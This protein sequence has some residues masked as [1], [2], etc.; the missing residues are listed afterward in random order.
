[1]GKKNRKPV[2]QAQS[3][4][5]PCLDR[6]TKKDILELCNQLLEKCTRSN[7]AG[8][9]DWDEFMEIFNLVEKIREK[10]KHL[11]S[12]SQKTSR[13]WSS[14]L[15]WLQENNVDTSRVTTDEFPV[16]GF[17]LRATQNLKEGDLFLSVPRKLMISTETASR[18]QIGFL[19]EEDKLLQSM[20]NVVLAIHLLSESKN[21]DSFWYPYISCLPKNYNTTLYFNPEELKLLKGSPVLTEAFN[22]YQRIARQYAYFYKLFQNNHYAQKFPLREGFTYDDYRWAVSTV[23]T[24]QN[25]IPSSNGNQMINALI[26]FW[27]MCNHCNGQLST[28]FDLVENCGKCYAMVN[29][30]KEEQIFIFYGPRSNSELLIHNGFVYMENL[31]DTLTIKLG[32]SKSDP[33]YALKSEVLAR[34][35]M[36]PSKSFQLNAGSKPVSRELLSFLRVICMNQENLQERFTGENAADLLS[37]MGNEEVI[38]SQENEMKVWQF[39]ATRVQLLLKTYTTSLETDEH[40]DNNELSERAKLSLQMVMCEKRILNSTLDYAKSKKLSLSTAE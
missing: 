26:P 21:S 40:L 11:V 14:F 16:Y 12:V 4:G 19:I 2:S 15:Q 5:V 23:M 35:S 38:V 13:E 18:S 28:D 37:Q 20:P 7:G 32:I 3:S 29:F 25:Q 36:L 31:F 17:G 9:K 30:Q 1:M 22:H 34:L 33:L 24:R 10:Q 8:P 39:I 27:D 6:S